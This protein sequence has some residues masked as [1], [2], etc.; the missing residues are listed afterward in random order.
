MRIS[1]CAEYGYFASV[2][3]DLRKQPTAPDHRLDR[4]AP[5][6]VLVPNAALFDLRLLD[7]L[8]VPYRS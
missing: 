3:H 7:D 5:V 2:I 1:D 8:R 4:Y 6:I